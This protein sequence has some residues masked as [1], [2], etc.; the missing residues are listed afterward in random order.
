MSYDRVPRINW[1]YYREKL[2]RVDPIKNNG[3]I[4]KVVGLVLESAGP[5]GSIGELCHLC[6]EERRAIPAEIVGFRDDRVLLMPLG[7]TRGIRPGCPVVA[8][9]APHRVRVGDG[10]LG[11]ILNGLG[12]FIDDG[13]PI[14]ADAEYPVYN[15]PPHP[16]RRQRIIEPIQTGIRAIDSLLTCGK[17]QR[18][19]IFSGS[20]VGKSLLLGMIARYTS[21]S[22]NVIALIGERG[23]EVREFIERDLGEE[24]LKR[25]VVIVATS[26]TPALVRILGAMVAI[27]VAEYFRDR[28]LDVMFMMDSV[29]RFAMAQREVGLAVG[30]P[31][32]TR[33]Y[34]PSVFALLPKFLERAGRTDHAGSITGLYTILVEGDDMNEPVADQVRSI[35]D[36]HVVLSRQLAEANHYPAIDILNSVSRVMRDMVPAEHTEASQTI[37][38]ALAVYQRAQDLINIG[39]YKEGNN[40]KIDWAIGLYD[41]IVSFLRQNFNEYLNFEECVNKMKE[42][43][44]SK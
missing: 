44:T 17:G 6:P 24:G 39:A 32:S 5:A 23:R 4:T 35:L 1:E 30:E 36:G 37:R 42:L 7:D 15:T 12:E 14:I 20:G 33:G 40:P 27:T 26:D 18:V 16:L 38:E 41:E 22:V 8:T 3:R 29:T 19:G 28:G 34:T 10:L 43:A 9:G 11:R 25:S 2:S 13:P 21:A 31:P